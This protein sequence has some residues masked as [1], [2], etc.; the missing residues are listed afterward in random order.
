MS[1]ILTRTFMGGYTL[2]V[3]GVW[4][5]VKEDHLAFTMLTNEDGEIITI[6]DKHIFV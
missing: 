6:P 5:I 4:G 1:I 3:N 2:R